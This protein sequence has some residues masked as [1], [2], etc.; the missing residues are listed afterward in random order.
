MNLRDDVNRALETA[1]NEKLL[2][3]LLEA[4]VTIASNDKF[5]ASEFLTS[6]DAFTSIIIVSQVKGCR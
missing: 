5:N 4:K 1:R 3:S 2:V 6:F